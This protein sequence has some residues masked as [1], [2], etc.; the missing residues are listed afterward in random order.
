MP[1]PSRFPWLSKAQ[2]QAYQYRSFLQQGLL[3][4][5][6]APSQPS[7]Q[8]EP[9]WQ[10]L[11]SGATQLNHQSS[12]TI[13]D[14]LGMG[15]QD[16]AQ[17]KEAPTPPGLKTELLKYQ[18]QGLAWMLEKENPKDVSAGS[19]SQFWEIRTDQFGTYYFNLASNCQSRQKP[20]LWR[21]GILADDMPSRQYHC[22]CRILLEMCYRELGRSNTDARRAISLENI[23]LSRAEQT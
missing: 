5:H 11:L 17:L 14:T 15:V 20:Q 2:Q 3:P 7:E 12:Q 23:R 8:P 18:K 10:V 4:G 21:G 16:L 9:I 6:P 13:L 22:C 19:A 1:Q